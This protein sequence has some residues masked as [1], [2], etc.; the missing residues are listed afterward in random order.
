[1]RIAFNDSI[2]GQGGVVARFAS[3]YSLNGLRR[4]VGLHSVQG[5]KRTRMAVTTCQS[6]WGGVNPLECL[7]RLTGLHTP[8]RN[9]L[10]PNW[11]I[12][13]NAALTITP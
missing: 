11:P 8:I 13:K 6:F 10:N 1:M 12:E 3:A 7:G 5:K 9:L 2:R 4:L